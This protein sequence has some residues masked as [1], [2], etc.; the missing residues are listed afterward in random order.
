MGGPSTAGNG[1]ISELS[2]HCST[3]NIPLN[4][5]STHT[6]GVRG[7]FDANGH[8]GLFLIPGNAEIANAVRGTRHRIDTS[9]MP[10]LPLY[11]TEWST[12]YSSRDPVHDSYVSAPYL[13]SNLKRCAGLAS[14]MSYWTFTDVFEEEG[15]AP[16]P[17]HGGFGLIHLQGLHKPSYYAYK[18]LHALGDTELKNQDTDST[19]CRDSTGVQALIWNY[20]YLPQDAPDTIFYKRDLPAKPLGPVKL[21]LKNLPSGNYTLQIYAIGYDRNDVYDDFLRMGSPANPTREQIKTLADKSSGAPM[22]TEN[23][24][25]KPGEPFQHTLEMRENDVYLVTLKSKK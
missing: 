16:T 13:L 23:V 19:I 14:A 3:N 11:Y 2:A 1:W 9:P 20:T 25:I 15:P 18:F 5:L 21:I 12:S 6:Y 8:K 24:E 22:T 4:F 17:F 10:A 7:D